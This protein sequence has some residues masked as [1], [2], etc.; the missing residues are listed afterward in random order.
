MIHEPEKVK[1]RR[2]VTTV[3]AVS[4]DDNTTVVSRV[5]R[6]HAVCDHCVIKRVGS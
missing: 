1:S 6:I 5:C 4:S 2:D 3:H